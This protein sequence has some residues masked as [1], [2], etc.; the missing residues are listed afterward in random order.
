[1][2]TRSI[3]TAKEKF[4]W[5]LP[6]TQF[7]DVLDKQVNEGMMD[8][9]YQEKKI[10]KRDL[11]TAKIKVVKHYMNFYDEL[12]KKT[13]K[14]N[15]EEIYKVLNNFLSST[16]EKLML[17]ESNPNNKRLNSLSKSIQ[18]EQ[19]SQVPTCLVITSSESASS[20]DTQFQAMC[21]ELK[22]SCGS[23]NIMLDD[24]KCA[25]MKSTIETIKMRL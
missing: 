15:N 11:N 10:A 18:K 12:I 20:I 17:A 4:Q 21:D 23:I 7:T 6:T 22:I 9:K 5:N 19:A 16:S 24:K 14:K 1:M 3:G 25:T 2:Y 13:I 8:S